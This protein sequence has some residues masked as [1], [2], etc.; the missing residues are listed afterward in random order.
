MIVV[1]TGV[2]TQRGIGKPDY[3]RGVSRAIERP[4]LSL[5][6]NETLKGFGIAFSSVNTGTHIGAAHLTIMTDPTAHFTTLRIGLTILNVTD[7]SSGTIIA[8]TETT[9]TVLGLTGGVSNQW[10]NLDV[11]NIPSPFAWIR[12][13]LAAGDTVSLIDGETGLSL[14]LTVPEGY[15]LAIL[16]RSRSFTQDNITWLFFDGV[17]YASYGVLAA[18]MVEYDAHVVEHGTHII[19]PTGETT[20]LIDVK[21]TNLG[22][23]DMEGAWSIR[24]ILKAVGTKPLPTTKTVRC[25]W[26]G[27]EETVPRETTRWICPNCG[28]LNLYYN[29]ANLRET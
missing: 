22:G 8:N 26:C 9:V 23:A 29:F 24:T 17:L 15:T 25:K 27:H 7:G 12:A 20:H 5:K 16:T 2:A 6:Y 14:P 21:V 28:Q 10:N 19:D 18:G 1:E 13:P 4:G 11:Y 3:T